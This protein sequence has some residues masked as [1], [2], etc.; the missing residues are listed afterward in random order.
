MAITFLT[1]DELRETFAPKAF[2]AEA[3]LPNG[4]DVAGQRR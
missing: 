3:P 4:P 1:V 2:G